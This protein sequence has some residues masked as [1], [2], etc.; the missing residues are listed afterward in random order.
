MVRLSI[1]GC[2]CVHC[3]TIMTKN[4]KCSGCGQ[5]DPV[6]ISPKYWCENDEN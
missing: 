5:V 4:L 6:T 1:P 3:G 2:L